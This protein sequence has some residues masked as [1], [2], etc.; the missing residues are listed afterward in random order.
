MSGAGGTI[1]IEIPGA[2]V[3]KGRP[4][5]SARNGFAR[6][7]TP[8][9]TRRYEDLIRLA[10][11][12]QMGERPLMEGPLFV[13]VEA[14]VPIPK[15]L[16]TKP[17]LALIKSGH[18]RPTTRPDLDNYLKVI[19]GLNGVVWHDDSQVVQIAGVKAY[20]DRPRL[21]VIIAPVLPPAMAI[22]A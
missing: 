11:G 18:L 7:Y 13:C 10:A 1:R 4:R 8:A 12:E 15:T 3:A 2:P 17:K 19:D 16:S 20:S 5:L 9:K 21:V 6:A 14:Y 22:A